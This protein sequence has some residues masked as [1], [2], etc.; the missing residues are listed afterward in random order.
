M[1]LKPNGGVYEPPPLPG[2]LRVIPWFTGPGAGTGAT[3]T[4]MTAPVT[5]GHLGTVAVV[6][7]TVGV[8]AVTE[9]GRI[10]EV[11]EEHDDGALPVVVQVAL[12]GEERDIVEAAAS[13]MGLS[14]EAFTKEALLAL[15]AG[16][17]HQALAA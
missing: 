14:L 5:A 1:L 2:L 11:N 6:V 15:A 17:E 16:P 7:A 8:V 9:P 4:A 3:A 12:V 10:V 13:E